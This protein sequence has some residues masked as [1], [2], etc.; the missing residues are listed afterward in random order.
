MIGS[1]RSRHTKYSCKSHRCETTEVGFIYGRKA[2]YSK[3]Q[4]VQA[5]EDYLS[6]TK[7]ASQIAKELEMGR[8]D[9]F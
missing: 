4:K 3:Q 6:G 5:C 7:S 2:K 9:A 8:E 1:H